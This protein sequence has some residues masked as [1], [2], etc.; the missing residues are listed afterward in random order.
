MRNIARK[1]IKRIQAN[2]VT[3]L[4]L[5]V[6]VAVTV[7]IFAKLFHW[8]DTALPSLMHALSPR[9]P[10]SWLPGAGL[11]IFLLVIYLIGLLARNW[12]GRKI[13]EIGNALII[14]IPFFNKVYIGLHQ[15]LDAIVTTRK[16]K[17]FEKVVL[18]EFP[19]PG[20]WALGFLTSRNT[21]E[22]ARKT[23]KEMVSVYIPKSPNPTSGFV[24]F[25][26]ESGIIELDMSVESALK[27]VMSTGL[28]STDQLKETHHKYT[29][30]ATLKRFNW[31]RS[32][33]KYRQGDLFADPRD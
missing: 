16:R 31:L 27:A 6:P 20:V 23:G 17:L 12:L 22:I 10:A 19:R 32:F 30:P 26:P 13:I 2:I 4:L 8:A 14:R 21:G 11:L 33:R 15:I 28:I 24:L 18:V 9:F 1:V 3:G 5:L 29:I 25:Y 7:F